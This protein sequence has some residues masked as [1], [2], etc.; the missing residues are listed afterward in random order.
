MGDTVAEKI[1]GEKSGMEAK[2]GRLVV[3][4]ID[5]IM[6]HD[7]LG[8]MAIEA[9]AEMGKI[10]IPHPEKIC[11]MTDHL[12]PTPAR[13]YAQMQKQMQDFAKEWGIRQHGAGDGIFHQ[14]LAEKEVRHD[15]H[16]YKERR[17]LC[18]TLQA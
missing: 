2:D 17:A 9:L 6:A 5:V 7:S 16:H 11:F 18:H 8:P 12:V 13:N 15:S 3:A 10:V 4:D 14:L 1:L